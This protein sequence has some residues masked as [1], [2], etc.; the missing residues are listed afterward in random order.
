MFKF[1][2]FLVNHGVVDGW[3]DHWYTD[4]SWVWRI[5]NRNAAALLLNNNIRSNRYYITKAPGYHH[6]L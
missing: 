3:V 2:S 6:I 1:I 4:V 5:P